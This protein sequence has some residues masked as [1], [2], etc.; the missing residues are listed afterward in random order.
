MGLTVLECAGPADGEANDQDGAADVYLVSNGDNVIPAV[1][2]G[3]LGKAASLLLPST[4][5]EERR[6][7][8]QSEGPRYQAKGIEPEYIW[9]EMQDRAPC[10]LHSLS[11]CMY[12]L[13]PEDSDLDAET[14][15]PVFH[16]NHFSKVLALL[17]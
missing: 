6:K 12:A 8:A 17:D 7:T 9:K 15:N 16:V 13:D 4:A 10:A 11:K 3:D 14:D 5:S 1:R 2:S